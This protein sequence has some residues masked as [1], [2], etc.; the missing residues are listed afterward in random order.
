MDDPKARAQPSHISEKLIT[1]FEMIIS[2]KI[3][4]I[5]IP[6][7][8]LF[9]NDICIIDLRKGN[10]EKLLKILPNVAIFTMKQHYTMK[11]KY[12][13]SEKFIR[14]TRFF[15]INWIDVIA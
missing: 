11:N 3:P 15:T 12:S 2:E 8:N 13:E 7:E 4:E 6:W 1:F 5:Q 9:E 14:T 10:L